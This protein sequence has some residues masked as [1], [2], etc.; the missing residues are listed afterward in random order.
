MRA[1]TGRVEREG[2]A[3]GG[4]EEGRRR[5]KGWAV[6]S[7]TGPGARGEMTEGCGSEPGLPWP[8]RARTRRVP[9]RRL[10]RTL[11]ERRGGQNIPSAAAR[12]RG[13]PPVH[14]PP[15]LTEAQTSTSV[16]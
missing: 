15:A 3:G 9:F 13:P 6:S 4:C 7:G 12:A 8:A 5:R 1:G 2:R 16:W 14:G 11:E 10:P